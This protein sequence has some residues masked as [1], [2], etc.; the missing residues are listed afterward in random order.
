MNPVDLSNESV[1]R[2]ARRVA[3]L[4]RGDAPS[5]AIDAAEVARRTGMSR[6]WVYDHADDLGATRLGGGRRGSLRFDPASVDAFLAR[7]DHAV[8]QE[9]SPRPEAPRRRRREGATAAGA[10]LLPIRGA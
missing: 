5:G 2:I 8:A 7:R 1:D 3:E 4:L 10:P 6:G 9:T